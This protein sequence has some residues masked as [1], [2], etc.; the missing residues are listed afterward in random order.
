MWSECS[1]VSPLC[2][3]PGCPVTQRAVCYRDTEHISH[4]SLYLG[5]IASPEISPSLIR[6]PI[7][8]MVSNSVM[9]NSCLM[10]NSW[11]YWSPGAPEPVISR[12]LVSWH[13]GVLWSFKPWPTLLYALHDNHHSD[14]LY[15]QNQLKLE[16][17]LS[18]SFKHCYQISRK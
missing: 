6:S 12:G 3:D 14:L 8:P 4:I 16:C 15:W 5:G 2:R 7:N 11:Q 18:A 13:R 17:I 9:M 1:V 10:C